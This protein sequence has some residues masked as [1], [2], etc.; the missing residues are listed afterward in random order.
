VNAGQDPDRL[1]HGQYRD[2]TELAKRTR[3]HVGSRTAPV[4][5]FS[6][7][8]SL[9][10]WTAGDRVLDVGGGPGHLWEETAAEV[11]ELRTIVES[12][13]ARDGGV[14]RVDKYTGCVV[15]EGRRPG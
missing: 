9:V 8:G 7:F 1:R 13:I 12:A 14:F 11:A 4:S 10:P 5:G 2:S 6:L 15:A 3:V